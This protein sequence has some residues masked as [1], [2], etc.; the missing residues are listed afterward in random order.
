MQVKDLKEGMKRVD[1]EG[2]IVEKGDTREV[3]STF[4]DATFRIA[5]AMLADETGSIKLTLW[6]DQIEEVQ[7]ADNVQIKNGYVTTF[8]GQIQLNIGKFGSLKVIRL[9]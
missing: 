5:D 7:V 4:K 2:K 3:K 1:V 6:D 9:P 8:K